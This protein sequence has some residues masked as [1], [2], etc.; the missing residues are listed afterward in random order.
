MIRRGRSWGE[1]SGSEWRGLLLIGGGMLAFAYYFLWWLERIHQLSIWL[2]LAFL[3][4]VAYGVIQILGNWA[5][6]LAT[7]W[8]GIVPVLPVPE[9]M[10]VD[11]FLTACGEDPA[12]VE[13]ALQKAVSMR[14]HHKTWLL[15]DGEDYR[16]AQMAS[17]LGAGYLVRNGRSDAKAGNLNAALAR[18]SGDIVVIFDIDHAPESEFL[19][20]TLGYF[21]FPMIGFVQVMLTFENQSDGWVAKAAADSSLDFYN[22]TS[23][24]SDGLQSTTLVG[25]NALIRREA[26]ESIEGYQPGLAEDL[27]TSI[28]LHA[29]GWRSVYVPEPL[30]P[31][32]APPDLTAWFTQQMKWARGVFELLLTAYPRYFGRMP[33]GKRA[34]YA[35]RMTYY[36]IGIVVFLHLLATIFALF[37]PTDAARAGLEDYLLHLA[38]LGTAVVVIRQLALRRWRHQSLESS[39]QIKPMVLV[40]ASWPV[41]TLAWAMALLRLPLDFRPTPKS[42]SGSL[43]IRW[44]MPHTAVVIL[45]TWGLLRY[46]A[47]PAALSLL[48]WGFAGGALLAHLILIAQWVWFSVAKY[49]ENRLQVKMTQMNSVKEAKFASL[50]GEKSNL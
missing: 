14:G 36:W 10:S 7:H 17:R 12:L 21:R 45:L 13:R 24:G 25:S 23:I 31:G 30:A 26:L 16:L 37:S 8:R 4:A 49:R 40:F 35:V 19:E 3:F 20:R 11:V 5:L 9:H 2:L 48:I 29:A 41:Y 38:P 22:P 18:T 27:A 34:A 1:V 47:Q 28:A 6:Y 15:D 46:V 32:Y 42:H 43:K 33:R 39:R 44:M 50:K